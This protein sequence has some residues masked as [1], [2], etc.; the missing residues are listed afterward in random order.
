MAG[1]ISVNETV[2]LRCLVGND[3]RRKALYEACSTPKPVSREEALSAFDRHWQLVEDS[4]PPMRRSWIRWQVAVAAAVLLMTI[5]VVG[6]QWYQGTTPRRYA[7]ELGQRKQFT[8]PDGTTV[9]LNGGSTLTL[10]PGFNDGRRRVVFR[11]EGFFDIRKDAARP[12]TIDV[13]GAAVEV[14]GTVFNLRA[15]EEEGQVETTLLS[16][17]VALMLAADPDNKLLLDPGKKLVIYKNRSSAGVNRMEGEPAGQ[18]TLPNEEIAVFSDMNV[19]EQ[20]QVANDVLW[21]ADKLVFDGDNLELVASKLQ[22]WY[23]VDVQLA[24]SAIRDLKFS[25]IFQ[26]MA[27]D[28]VL[29]TLEYT[30]RIRFKHEAGVIVL[31]GLADDTHK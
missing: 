14:L 10:S 16:G 21:T 2:E 24:E 30:G 20:E 8:L 4:L 5:G 26:D 3:A 13:G 18:L 9:W 12:F 1:R 7:T 25:G 23:G 15:Y 28:S 22:K 6:Y 27:L 17:K 19:D 31:H 11:G 29:Q